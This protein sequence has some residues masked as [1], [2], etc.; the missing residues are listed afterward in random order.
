MQQ[1][2]PPMSSS[3]SIKQLKKQLKM[4]YDANDGKRSAIS[5]EIEFA[6]F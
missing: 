4:K 5:V 6:T 3:E 1:H 2:G